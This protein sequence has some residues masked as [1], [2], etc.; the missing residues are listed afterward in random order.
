M[1]PYLIQYKAWYLNG[2][3]HNATGPAVIYNSGLTFWYFNGRL[4]NTNGPAVLDSKGY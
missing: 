3:P 2:C 4:H 1:E